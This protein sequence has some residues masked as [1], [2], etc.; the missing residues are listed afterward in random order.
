M[1]ARDN[2]LRR[3][4]ALQ[5]KPPSPAAGEHEAVRA[6]LQAHP[7]G[8]RPKADWEPAARFRERALSLAS[9]CDEIATQ[10]GIPAAVAAYLRDNN[11]PL[12]LIDL[13]GC[14]A[15]QLR[16]IPPTTWYRFQRLLEETTTVCAVFT[17]R[18][19]IAAA[20]T[21]IT[22][23]S[24]FSLAALDAELDEWLRGLKVEA[25]EARGFS[26]FAAQNVAG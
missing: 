8:P 17:P 9:T 5:D 16:K 14:A 18:P 3:I 22:L 24:K 1:S 15:T 20:Q 11:L 2:I 21:R 23:R 6:H 4:R 13:V 10:A 25:S 7:Q 26:E 19:M 12:V